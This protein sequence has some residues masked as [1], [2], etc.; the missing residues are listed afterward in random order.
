[1]DPNGRT[2][3]RKAMRS[4]AS[5]PTSSPGG[6]VGQKGARRV[7]DMSFY[8]VGP[9]VGIPDLA[10][11]RLVDGPV[12]IVWGAQSPWLREGNF[13]PWSC[14]VLSLFKKNFPSAVYH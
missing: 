1:M 5:L 6:I 9:F 3:A 4:S 14:V 11:L 13:Y 10:A 7:A 2:G 12:C 8:V